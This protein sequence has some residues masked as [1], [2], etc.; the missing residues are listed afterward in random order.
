MLAKI[1]A[2]LGILQARWWYENKIKIIPAAGG[3]RTKF[4]ISNK[5]YPFAFAKNS[6][7]IIFYLSICNYLYAYCLISRSITLRQPAAEGKAKEKFSS[8]FQ[9]LKG[10]Y[11]EK[12]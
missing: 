2:L 11:F 5:F 6:Y 3:G 8:F 9:N 10:S 4:S 12:F 1:M 7:F